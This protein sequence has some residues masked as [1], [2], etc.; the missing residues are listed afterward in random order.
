MM[1]ANGNQTVNIQ[2][3]SN[4]RKHTLPIALDDDK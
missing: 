3:N 2:V 4:P 1:K